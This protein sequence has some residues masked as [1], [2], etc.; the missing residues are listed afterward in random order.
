MSVE[1]VAARPDG[2]ATGTWDSG[3]SPG[4]LIV[5]WQHPETRLIAPVG[6]LE[7]GRGLGDRFRYLRRASTVDG[8]LPFLSFPEWQRTYTSQHLFPLFSQRIMSPRR[9]DFSQFLYQLHLNEDATPW[10]SWPDRRVAAPVTRC[11]CS[12]FRLSMPTVRRVAGSSCTA[13]AMWQAGS[14]HRRSPRATSSSCRMIQR[15]RSTPKLSWCARAVGSGLATCLTSCSNTCGCS[16]TRVRFA[17]PSSMSTDQR[18]PPDPRLLVLLDGHA[19][20]DY[21]PMSGPRWQTY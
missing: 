7:H 17:S 1:E 8:F 21:Q 12:R 5:A 16:A 6:L 3:R 9:P 18:F 13:S 2:A 14:C 19:P 10:S 20:V 4:S 11:R 15:T